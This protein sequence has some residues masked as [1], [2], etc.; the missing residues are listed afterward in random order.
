MHFK[1]NGPPLET[2][3]LMVVRSVQLA[4]E[5]R[6]TAVGNILKEGKRSPLGWLCR[7]PRAPRL[8]WDK[9]FEKWLKEFM[10]LLTDPN[11]YSKT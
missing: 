4:R 11:S 8:I 2:M 9:G 1:K 7:V 5:G 3:V 10:L 6:H